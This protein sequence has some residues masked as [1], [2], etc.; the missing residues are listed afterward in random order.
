MIEM[1]EDYIVPNRLPLSLSTRVML[2]RNIAT[3]HGLVN[4]ALGFVQHIEF[5]KNKPFRVY[6]RFDNNSIW[7]LFYDDSHN[8]TIIE[9]V[10]QEF[11]Y[12]ERSI[13]RIQFP[14]TPAWASTIHKVQGITCDKIVLGLGKSVFAEGH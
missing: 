2:I 8:A 13:T 12:K 10:S 5:D 3:E 6:V 9:Q 7:R 14:I 11:Y 4:G 1:L